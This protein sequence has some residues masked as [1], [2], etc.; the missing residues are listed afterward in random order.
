MREVSEI[1]VLL[2]DVDVL[3]CG[4]MTREYEGSWRES[5]TRDG[6][7]GAL[8]YVLRLGVSVCVLWLVI[9]VRGKILDCGVDG[10]EVLLIYEFVSELERA[11]Y[12][13]AYRT[14]AAA[15]FGVLDVVVW[16]LFVV[17]RCG[18]LRDVLLIEDVGVLKVDVRDFVDEYMFVFNRYFE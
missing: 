7:A 1:E 6:A 13:W 12:A 14:V 3:V 15:A 4:L 18:D 17:S 9:E 11:G 16:V 8:K 10:S 2:R 5:W